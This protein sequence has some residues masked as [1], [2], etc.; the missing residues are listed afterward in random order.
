M[1]MQNVKETNQTK[2]CI[3]RRVC[4]LIMIHPSRKQDAIII[5]R[6]HDIGQCVVETLSDRILPIVV[7]TLKCKLRAK[8]VFRL[9]E[10]REEDGL[11]GSSSTASSPTRS[12]RPPQ[13]FSPRSLALQVSL[14][15]SSWGYKEMPS[16]YADQ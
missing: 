2:N 7:C 11:V 15:S 1:H 5:L 4:W 14:P 8:F 12:N 3:L 9:S 13:E 6:K 10:E 16:I